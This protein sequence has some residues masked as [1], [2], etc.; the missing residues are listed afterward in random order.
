MQR[1]FINKDQINGNFITIASND[2]HHIKNVMRMKINDNVIACDEE[3]SYQCKINNIS[4]VITLEIINIIDTNN[5]LNIHVTIAHGLVRREKTEEVIRRLVETGCYSYIPV[6]MER[7]IVKLNN[8]NFKL[9]R[10]EKIIKEA[11]EQCQ[12]TN[13]MNISMPISFSSLINDINNYD[14]VLFAHVL[15]AKEN[16]LKQILQTYLHES[17]ISNILCIIGP[18]GGFSDKEKEQILHTKAKPIGLG[19]RILRTE[20]APLFLMSIIAYET[21]NINDA[22]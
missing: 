10:Y 2:V 20:T 13:L 14:L 12:R 11:S 8:N 7:S 6:E 5:D 22:K 15:Y 3:K 1:Y 17:K 4:N 19:K 18:E 21:E 16:N 9:E